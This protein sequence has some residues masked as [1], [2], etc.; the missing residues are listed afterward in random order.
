[1]GL[2]NV[3]SQ[4]IIEK[5]SLNNLDWARVARF[6]SFGYLFAVEVI[7]LGISPRFSSRVHFFDIGT[8]D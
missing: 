6:A 5:K 2:G 1:M 3:I 7:L 4:S 8:M